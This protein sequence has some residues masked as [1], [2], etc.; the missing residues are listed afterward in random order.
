LREKERREESTST[1]SRLI[2]YLINNFG[3]TREQVNRLDF[4]NQSLFGSLDLNFF[5]H[6]YSNNDN[7]TRIDLKDNNLDLTNISVFS[8]L[9]NLESLEISNYKK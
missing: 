8:N 1:S 7:L 9:I 5:S 3:K 6:F 4:S 2:K